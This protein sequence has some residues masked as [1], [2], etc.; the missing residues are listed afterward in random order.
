VVLSSATRPM[1]FLAPWVVDP[2]VDRFGLIYDITDFSGIISVL[3]R[4]GSEPQDLSFRQMFSFQRRINRLAGSHRMQLEKYLGDGAFFSSR[5]ALPL[6]AAAVQIQRLYRQELE[7]GFPFDRGLRIAVNYGQYRIIPIGRGAPGEPGRYEF[8]GHSLVELSRLTTG[9][10]DQE[11]DEIKTLLVSLGYPE[12]TVYRF[13]A[14]LLKSN[15]DVGGGRR[16]ERRFRAQINRNG[17]LSNEGIVT[18]EAFISRLTQEAPWKD[19]SVGWAGDQAFVVIPLDEDQ[20]LAAGLR[21]LG[22]ATLKGLEQVP[23][24]EVADAADLERV[25]RVE[26][27]GL[28]ASLEQLFQRGRLDTG[29]H[30]SAPSAGERR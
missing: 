5:R 12:A 16:P 27:R 21:K 20:N 10:A 18:T 13:F 19:L 3:R 1:D 7:Q 11:I 23:V 2:L 17:T 22:L 30:A 8:F 28:L 26:S 29:R 14:P 6:L 24:Y 25:E 15:L 4:S 9:K